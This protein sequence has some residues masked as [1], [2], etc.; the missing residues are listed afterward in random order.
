MG[1]TLL[2]VDDADRGAPV[3]AVPS[4]EERYAAALAQRR[5]SR[6]APSEA[7]RILRAER[8]GSVARG[9]WLQRTG[10]FLGEETLA[11]PMPRHRSLDID[12]ELDFALAEVLLDR[13]HDDDA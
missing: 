1:G 3:L 13:R 4:H 5:R 9:E 8:R 12:S 2:R 6:E 10:S 7:A 11:Y